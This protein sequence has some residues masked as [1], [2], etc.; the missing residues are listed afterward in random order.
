MRYLVLSWVIKRCLIELLKLSGGSFQLTPAV[1]VVCMLLLLA[2]GMDEISAFT[3]VAACLNNLGPGLG[4]VAANF[5]S[6]N[7]FS[8]WV[9]NC[10]NVIWSIRNIHFVSIIYSSFLAFLITPFNSHNKHLF[11]EYNTLYLGISS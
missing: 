3:A 1:F 5:S 6:I 4:E 9:F 11:A 10:C 8:K 7:D 2:A